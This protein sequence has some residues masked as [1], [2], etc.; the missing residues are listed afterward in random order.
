M[1]TLKDVDLSQATAMM[2]KIEAMQKTLDAKKRQLTELLVNLNLE[3]YGTSPS[4]FYKAIQ[5]EYCTEDGIIVKINSGRIA[6]SSKIT[7]NLLV[8]FEDKFDET[9]SFTSSHCECTYN[10]G[11]RI[12]NVVQI[13]ELVKKHSR[14][15]ERFEEILNEEQVYNPFA[16]FGN[17]ISFAD[18][19]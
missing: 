11:R 2:E 5:K 10:S 8:T 3:Y 9:T 18:F 14:Q 12:H 4:K 16:T 1:R 7:D 19:H 6:I 15:F 13:R 17:Y